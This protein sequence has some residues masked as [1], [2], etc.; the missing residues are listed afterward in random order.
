[1]FKKHLFHGLLAGLLSSI[2]CLVFMRVYKEV[3]FVDFS[4]VMT[5]F[6]IFGACIFGCVLASVGFFTASK[7]L[8]RYG[9]IVF[10][11]L[12]TIFTFASIIGPIMFTFPPELDVEGIEEITSYFQPFAMTLHFFPALAWYTVKP[13]FLK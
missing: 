9:E 1:M 12:F 3:A 13:I 7:I 6:N 2:A 4:P 5:I 10:N 11:F 8:P